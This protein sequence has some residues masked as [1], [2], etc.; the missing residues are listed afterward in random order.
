MTPRALKDHGREIIETAKDHLVA[1][2][3]LSPAEGWTAAEWAEAA[4][5]L[6]DGAKFPAVLTHHV[7]HVLLAEGRVTITSESGGLSRYGAA[8]PRHSHTGMG[9]AAAATAAPHVWAASTDPADETGESEIVLS[10][11]VVSSGHGPT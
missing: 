2:L 4:G 6:L 10:P 9:A 1:A 8:A 5:V 11:P 3:A 7:A